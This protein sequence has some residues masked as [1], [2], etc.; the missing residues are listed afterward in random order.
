MSQFVRLLSNITPLPQVSKIVNWSAT[1]AKST[2]INSVY[3]G[4]ILIGSYFYFE[5]IIVIQISG[6]VKKVVPNT[7]NTSESDCELYIHDTD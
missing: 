5:V 7:L 4:L 6:M 1:I 3:E 2:I